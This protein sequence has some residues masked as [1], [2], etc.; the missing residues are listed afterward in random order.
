MLSILIQDDELYILIL[1]K[2]FAKFSGDHFQ[3]EHKN[4]PLCLTPLQLI[5]GGFDKLDGGF[6]S[7]AWLVLTGC[8]D[9]Q[10]TTIRSPMCHQS[11]HLFYRSHSTGREKDGHG[12]NVLFLS[13]T[14]E[15]R[16]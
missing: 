11:V 3:S 5:E 9:Q 10:V 14:A 12:R 1:E 2:A 15:P 6:A 7:L 4:I 16:G 8:E 13:G